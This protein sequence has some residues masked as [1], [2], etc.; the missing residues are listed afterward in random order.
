MIRNLRVRSLE[1]D[2]LEVLWEIEDASCNPLDLSFV[3]ERSESAGGPFAPVSPSLRDRYMF[4]DGNLPQGNQWRALYYRIRVTQLGRGTYVSASVSQEPEADLIALEL[5]RHHQLLFREFA[6]RQCWV[7]PAR[8]FGARCSCWNPTLKQRTRSRCIA[9]FD[10]GFVGGYLAPIETWVSI[11]PAVSNENNMNVGAAQPVNT[12]ARTGYYPNL[13]PRDIIVEMENKRWRI[14]NVSAP[15]HG[16]AQIYQELTLHLIPLG[17]IEYR[18]KVVPQE[19]LR[20][21]WG[22]PERNFSNPQNLE[23]AGFS[24]TPT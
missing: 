16:R 23:N 1:L 6:G 24:R 21:M 5:R 14:A 7:L 12:T 11:D 22:S 4:V 8:T 2:F 10:T 3:V 18:F 19:A 15:E 20:Y 17:D 9:C 13:K